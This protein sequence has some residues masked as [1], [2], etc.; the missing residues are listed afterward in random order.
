MVAP[1][2]KTYGQGQGVVSGDNLNTF[3]QTCDTVAQ[4]R[5]LTGV[6]GMEVNARGYQAPGDGGGGFY[7]WNPGAIGPDNGSTIILPVGTVGPGG[8]VRL[9]YNPSSGNK[10]ASLSFAGPGSLGDNQAI[11]CAIPIGVTLASGPPAF[12]IANAAAT[13]STVFQVSRWHASALTLLG[14]ATFNPAGTV[15]VFAGFASTVGFQP[16]DGLYIQG[17]PS[18]DSTLATVGFTF[19]LQVM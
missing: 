1:A 6:P 7:Y 16:G 8:W 13:G 12:G 17:P 10:Y 9:P 5:S 15:A 19:A 14:T 18:P 11:L 2:L 4:L 3:L